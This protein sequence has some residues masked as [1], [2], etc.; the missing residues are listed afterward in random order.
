MTSFTQAERCLRLQRQALQYFLDNQLSGGLILDRQ[1]NHGSRTATGLCSTAATGMGFIALALA[2]A[3]PYR[4]LSRTEA[5]ARIRAGLETAWARLPHNHGIMPHFVH[6]NAL[7]PFGSDPLSTVDSAW[8]LA[9]GLWAANFLRERTLKGLAERLYERVDWH[10]WTA[11]GLPGSRGLL[12]HGQGQNGRF[13]NCVWDRLNGETILLYVL[14]AG[15]AEL[16]RTPISYISAAS[17][18][19]LRDYHDRV[20]ELCLD[21]EWTVGSVVSLASA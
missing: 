10:Y 4:L 1:R 21:Q 17:D 19:G 5:V 20:I 3:P 13:L 7:T 18:P 12:Y 11:P 14:A 6:P 16:A 2:A 8:L 9:G 15:A